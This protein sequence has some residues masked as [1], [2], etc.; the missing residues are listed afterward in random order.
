MRASRRF[1]HCQS[2]TPGATINI[3]RRAWNSFARLIKISPQ[4]SF[5]CS[6]C[7]QYHDT[8][9]CDG[10]MLGFRKDLLTLTQPKQPPHTLLKG[11]KHKDRVLINDPKASSLLMK[12]TDV[13]SY[14]KKLCHH[15]RQVQDPQGFTQKEWL[16]ST[17]RLAF[18]A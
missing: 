8:I 7:E 5:Q 12:Y 18:E 2:S 1:H 4:H 6:L 15:P 9:I 10:T 16:H 13:S 17:R 11:S 3:M 14:R